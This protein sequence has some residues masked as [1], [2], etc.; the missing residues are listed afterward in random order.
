[1]HIALDSDDVVVAFLAGVCESI[2]RDYDAHITPEDFTSWAMAP[3][4]EP[5]LGEPWWGWMRRH[6]WLWGEK[7]KPVP[8]AIGGI[9]S[10]RRNGHWLEIV[11]NKPEWAESEV[12][13]WY[14]RYKPPV[15]QVT[16]VPLE[17]PER[18][19]KHDVTS[20]V[21]LVDD[22]PEACEEW[23]A[24]RNDRFAFLFDQPHNRSAAVRPGVTRVRDWNHIVQLFPPG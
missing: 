20:A 10:L 22:K 7:F 11:T 21:L 23:A 12:W 24:S 18:R 4:V 16:I 3:V 6:A 14:G 19:A 8:G 2:N 1:M 5:I 17:G 13:K 9:E 15:N